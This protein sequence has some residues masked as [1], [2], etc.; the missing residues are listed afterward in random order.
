[1]CYIENTFEWKLLKNRNCFIDSVLSPFYGKFE[2]TEN[3]KVTIL[4]YVLSRLMEKACYRNWS[5]G[6]I[7]TG[8]QTGGNFDSGLWVFIFYFL[9]KFHVLY[10]LFILFNAFIRSFYHT[11]TVFKVSVSFMLLL[12]SYI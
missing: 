12:I 4:V 10:I 9:R 1:M 7:Q 8:G 6:L 5:R 11:L 2:N 3:S